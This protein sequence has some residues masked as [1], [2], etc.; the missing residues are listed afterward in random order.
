MKAPDGRA[1]SYSPYEIN[2]HNGL[3]YIYQLIKLQHRPGNILIG[4]KNIH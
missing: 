1:K 2:Q 3:I 4:R